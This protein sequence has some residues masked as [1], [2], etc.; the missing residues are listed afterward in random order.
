MKELLRDLSYKMGF[1][2]EINDVVKTVMQ[3]CIDNQDYHTESRRMGVNDNVAYAIEGMRIACSVRKARRD[4]ALIER[5][6]IR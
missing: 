3:R 4:N 5:N 1:D 2:G 6:T